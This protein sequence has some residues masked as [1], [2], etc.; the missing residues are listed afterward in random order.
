VTGII[1][2]QFAILQSYPEDK[3]V[4]GEARQPGDTK[5]DLTIHPPDTSAAE[6]VPKNRSDP[7]VTV[8]SEEEIVLQSGLPGTRVGVES[9]GRSLSLITEVNE[10]AVVLI[11]FG[12]L[13]PFDA[14]AD[15]LSWSPAGE[16][17]SP[18]AIAPPAGTKPYQDPETG[19]TVTVPESWVVTGVVPGHTAILHSYPENKYVGGEALAGGDT[20]CDLNIR[21]AGVSAADFVQQMRDNAAITILSEGEL[22]LASGQPGIRMELESLGRS[23]SLITEV[24]GRVVVLSCYGELAPFDEIALTIGANE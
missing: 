2:G 18:P 13:A 12:E 3:Y 23:L 14:I 1:P 4:G 21:P 11:C 6:V 16:G 7:P 19:V 8:L 22:S 15:T 20:K 24:N 17:T 9:M 5:C 10:R